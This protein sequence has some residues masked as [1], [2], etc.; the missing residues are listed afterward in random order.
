MVLFNYSTKELTAKT[1]YYGPGLCG[2]TT[3]LQVIHN[4]P[5]PAVD[6]Y[7]NDGLLLGLKGT[8]AQA[9]L[10]FLRARLQGG[11]LNKAQKGELHFP[12]PVGLCYDEVGHTVL[13][14]DAEELP[15]LEMEILLLEASAAEAAGDYAGA[16][17]A[18]RKASQLDP[19]DGRAATR[20]TRVRAN[21]N[22]SPTRERS[23]AVM[24][25]AVSRSR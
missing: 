9:E 17:V 7:V 19:T 12:L 10:H 23:D 5:D 20:L 16:M 1:V 3:N 11:K 4:S 6:V 18:L 22:D 13:D 25:I 24:S 8:M 15:G 14:P 21:S 2:K